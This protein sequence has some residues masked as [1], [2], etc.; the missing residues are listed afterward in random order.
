MWRIQH[1][2]ITKGD[3]KWQKTSV[4][5]GANENNLK[6]LDVTDSQRQICGF[7]RAFGIRQI[8]A[9]LLIPFMQRA[10]GDIWRVFLRMPDS[11]S[12]QMEKPDVEYIEGLSPAISIDQKTTNRNPRS[13]VGTVTEIHDY[14]RSAYMRSDWQTAL[15][16]LRK[17]YSQPVG[18]PDGR[19]HH[20]LSG[21][22]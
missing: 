5:R 12:G 16:G 19:Y 17:A 8:I 10:R 20:G 1:C 15:P 22:N 18:R 3:N 9:W 21:G 4:I 6:N 7:N 2:R 11:S 13:T 14:L